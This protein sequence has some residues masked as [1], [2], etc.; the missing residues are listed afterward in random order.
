MPRALEPI[1]ITV[2]CRPCNLVSHALSLSFSWF[3]RC[4]F[5]FEALFAYS[6]RS[7]LKAGERPPSTETRLI[8]SEYDEA[9]NVAQ[10]V[11]T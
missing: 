1:F 11:K 2:I 3:T 7:L 5:S 8:E 6:E 9:K 4:S 10:L